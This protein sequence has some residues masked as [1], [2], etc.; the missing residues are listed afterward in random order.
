RGTDRAPARGAG[1]AAP[2]GVRDAA[3]AAVGRAVRRARGSGLRAVKRW[4]SARN[5]RRIVALAVFLALWEAVSRLGW[6]D[7]FYAPAPSK[8]G[9]TLV[10]LFTDGQLWPHLEATF[11]AAIIGL[12]V[13]LVLGIVL[14]FAAALIP[15]VA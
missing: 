13:G 15:L 4:L 11:S 6:I 5:L 1:G 14:G 10:T 3:A 9:D 2:P 7:P 8:V 12:I